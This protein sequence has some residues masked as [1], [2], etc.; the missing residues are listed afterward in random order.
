MA[1]FHHQIKTLSEQR[2]EAQ[3]ALWAYLKLR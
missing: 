2:Q 3:A 1:A